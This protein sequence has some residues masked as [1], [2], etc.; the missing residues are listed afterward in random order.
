M[1]EGEGDDD[2]GDGR[3]EVEEGKEEAVGSE[4]ADALGSTGSAQ[5]MRRRLQQLARQ[6]RRL[7]YEVQVRPACWHA[8]DTGA[9]GPRCGA[10][11]RI[12]TLLPG[13]AIAAEPR[14]DAAPA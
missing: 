3:E 9:V 4:D 6:P 8:A 7:T 1:S 14:Q 10:M 13:I 11:G 5:Q 2:D 12:L